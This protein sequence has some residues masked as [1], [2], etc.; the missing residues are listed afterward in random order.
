MCPWTKFWG[1]PCGAPREGYMGFVAWEPQGPL[2]LIGRISMT[3]QVVPIR[4]PTNFF[5]S[6]SGIHRS[7]RAPWDPNG[8]NMDHRETSLSYTNSSC[9]R[10]HIR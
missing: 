7:P 9:T 3:P 1:P 8:S 2:G 10:Q 5:D 6:P 4:L